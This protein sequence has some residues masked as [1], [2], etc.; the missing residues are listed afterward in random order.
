MNEF[1]MQL[2]LC[3]TSKSEENTIFRLKSFNKHVIAK[4]TSLQVSIMSTLE[5]SF[6]V[7]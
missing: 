1:T 7:C 6:V 5:F 2:N 4:V 3:N